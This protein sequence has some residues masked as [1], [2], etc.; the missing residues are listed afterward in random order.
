MDFLSSQQRET[1]R[2]SRLVRTET[3]KTLNMCEREREIGD[4]LI[5]FSTTN[6]DDDVFSLSVFCVSRPFCMIWRR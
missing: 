2:N 4:G 6:N 3:G 1:K 5:N